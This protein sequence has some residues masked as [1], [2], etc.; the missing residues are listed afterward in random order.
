M[1]SFLTTAGIIVIVYFVWRW[2]SRSVSNIGKG[3][4]PAI[5]SAYSKIPEIPKKE[6]F[7]DP[8]MVKASTGISFRTEGDKISFYTMQGLKYA[9][10]I[11]KE[12]FINIEVHDMS[13][14]GKKFKGR[15]KEVAR[16]R[17]SWYDGEED[18]FGLR[19]I[20]EVKFVS[21]GVGVVE[22]TNQLKAA[23]YTELGR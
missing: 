3:E 6:P 5:V 15:E 10:S 23:L 8:N 17:V 7:V 9:M 2:I 14:K 4:K 19:D 1:E 13:L 22:R 16:L 12:D 20:K 21:E 11:P 18:E